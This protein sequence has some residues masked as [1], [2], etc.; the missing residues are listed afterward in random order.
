MSVYLDN[1]S[2]RSEIHA[3]SYVYFSSNKHKD[4]LLR[5]K[6][7]KPPAI[8]TCVYLVYLFRNIETSV[9]MYK[10]KNSF[11]FKRIN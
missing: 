10:T 11:I 8:A 6:T 4:I 3:S 2:A 5:S 1:I 9:K 7:I